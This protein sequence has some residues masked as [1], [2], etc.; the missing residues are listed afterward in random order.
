MNEY[1]CVLITVLMYTET[2][3]FYNFHVMKYAGN[4]FQQFIYVTNTLNSQAI[5][6]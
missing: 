2:L 4:I 3:I 1:S 6:K 5:Q